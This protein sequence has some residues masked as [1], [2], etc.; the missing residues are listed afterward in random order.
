[1]AIAST[2]LGE[3]DTT[4]KVLVI[5]VAIDYI[6][7][8]FAAGYSGKLKSKVGFKGIDCQK[9]WCFFFLSQPLL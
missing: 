9:R 4:L 6:A 5:I 3:W 2:F 8:V 7:G 1:M